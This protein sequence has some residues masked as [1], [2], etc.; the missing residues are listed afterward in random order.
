MITTTH[1]YLDKHDCGFASKRALHLEHALL[2]QLL[3]HVVAGLVLARDAHIRRDGEVEG[4]AF[5]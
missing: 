1:T 2:M 5:A 4:R 3:L